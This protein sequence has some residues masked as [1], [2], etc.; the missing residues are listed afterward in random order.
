MALTQL[1]VLDKCYGGQ[2]LG[3][4]VCK[5]LDHVVTGKNVKTSAAVCTKLNPGAYAALEKRRQKNNFNNPT[6]DNCKG[7]VYLLH[8]KQGYDLEK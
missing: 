4:K 7:Y 2:Y 1:H 5:Y 8:K 6:G 3:G